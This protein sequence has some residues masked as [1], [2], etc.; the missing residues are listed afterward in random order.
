MTHRAFP[1]RLRCVLA[2]FLLVFASWPA[3]ANNVPVLATSTYQIVTKINAGSQT[4]ILMRLQFTNRSR[5][6][7]L[8]QEVLLADFAQPPCKALLP[9]SLTLRP[10]SPQEI[11]QQFVVPRAELDQWQHGV[12]PRMILVF[13]TAT[14]A[15]I[16]QTI[17]LE[18][19]DARSGK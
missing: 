12:H 18:S 19:V 16:K 10:D 15:T 1:H 5:N 11:T 9:T 7:L 13:K 3:S 6:S 14:G 8:L 4:K 17:R 2:L